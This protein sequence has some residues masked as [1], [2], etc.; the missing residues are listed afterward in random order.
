MPAPVI[1][2]PI[3]D[4]PFAEP[5]HRWVLDDKGVP[6]GEIATGR[7]R[8]EFIVPV[9]PATHQV[10]A[11]AALDLDDAF[12]KREPNDYINEIRA[13]VGAW[14]ALGEAGVRDT[15]SPVTARLLRHWRDKTRARRLSFSQIETVIWAA[16]AISW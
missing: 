12:R 8:S 15:V 2:N 6:T 4:S 5:G 11:Q 3:L 14:R 10:Y 1:D 16:E 7:R 9:P 13:R